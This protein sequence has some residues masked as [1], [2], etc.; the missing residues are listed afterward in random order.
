ME[1]LREGHQADF[2]F[3]VFISIFVPLHPRLSLSL[4]SSLSL[5]ISVLKSV[6]SS[7]QIALTKSVLVIKE[8]L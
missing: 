3:Y 5:S 8:A 2:P 7:A 6:C 4:F 1:R